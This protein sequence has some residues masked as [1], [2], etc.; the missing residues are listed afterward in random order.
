MKVFLLFILISNHAFAYTFDEAI[1]HLSH[2]PVVQSIHQQAFLFKQKGQQEGSWGD[3]IFHVSMRN[4]TGRTVSFPTVDPTIM[5]SINFQISQK[6]ALTPVY[7]TKKK[8]LFQMA[9]AQEHTKEDQ[10]RKL[11]I[12]LWIHLITNRS[13]NEEM[14]ILKENL[15]WMM[16]TISV[17][18]KLYVNGTIS[19]QALLNIKIRKSEMESDI[20]NKKSQIKKQS[21]HL[22]YLVD[23]EGT[24]DIATIPWDFL[25]TKT[26]RTDL[27]DFKQKAFDAQLTSKELKLKATKLAYIPDMTLSLGY[28]KMLQHNK[29]GFISAGITWTLPLSRQKYAARL[30]AEFEKQKTIEEINQ[31]Q[32]LKENQTKKL[33][34]DIQENKSQLQ[35]IHQQAIPFARNSKQITSQSYRLGQSNYVDLLQ[36]ELQMQKLLL[37]SS[38]LKASLAKNQITYKYLIGDDLYRGNMNLK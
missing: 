14:Q 38:L 13:L 8:S 29:E 28:T 30:S 1:A 36:A 35:I 17:S 3:P 2:H 20:E 31:Y 24:L 4:M 22:K 7:G 26:I 11:I 27:Q 32:R 18:E 12:D 10:K 21:E 5:Q 15:D 16:N 34:H 19:Q 25:E 6:V 9:L 37:K 23:L 33:L